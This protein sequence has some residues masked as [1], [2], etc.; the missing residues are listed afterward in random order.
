MAE[1]ALYVIMYKRDGSAYVTMLFD[2]RTALSYVNE[3][4]RYGDG[5]VLTFAPPDLIDDSIEIMR[6]FRHSSL[7]LRLYTMVEYLFDMGSEY[8][9]SEPFVSED[10]FVW[11]VDTLDVALEQELRH[12]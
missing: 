5:C 2:A 10:D 12:E 7:M 11:F 1:R 3:A 8:L 6:E 9:G 4:G